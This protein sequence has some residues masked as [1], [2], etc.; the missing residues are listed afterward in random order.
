MKKIREKIKFQG[1]KELI[2]C[3]DKKGGMPYA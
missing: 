3:N 1:F 2:P